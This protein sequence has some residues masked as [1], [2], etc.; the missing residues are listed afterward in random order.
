MTHR[1]MPYLRRT[2]EFR[3]F[4]AL[5]NDEVVREYIERNARKIHL[6]NAGGFVPSITNKAFLTPDKRTSI[7][8]ATE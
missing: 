6:K 2:R 1:E 7:T 3:V 8:E 5:V 4:V